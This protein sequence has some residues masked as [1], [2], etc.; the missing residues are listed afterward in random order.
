[1][2]IE[3]QIQNILDR[4]FTRGDNAN[5]LKELLVLYNVRLSFFQPENCPEWIEGK[6]DC[7]K[8]DCT[9]CKIETEIEGNE[10]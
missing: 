3:K 8:P 5:A 9:F 10:A 7:K 2:N 6:G 4:N 1:M